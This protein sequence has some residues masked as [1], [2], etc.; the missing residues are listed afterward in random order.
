M[1]RAIAA[2][3]L[4]CAP[5]FAQPATPQ[6][7][8]PKLSFEVASIKPSPPPDPSGFSSGTRG[9]PGRWSCYNTSLTN[10]VLTAF[11][12]KSYQLTAPDWMRRELFDISAKVPAGATKEDIKLMLQNLL[13]E[14]FKLTYHREQKETPA[15]DLVIAK[16]GPKLTEFVEPAPLAEGAPKPPP[17]ADTEGRPLPQPGSSGMT[18]SKNAI[19]WS[20]SKFTMKQMASMLASQLGHPVTD[21]TGLTGF[22]DMQLSWSGT[23]AGMR[24]TVSPPPSGEGG[25]PSAGIPEADSGPT[26][27]T[28]LQQ[29]LGLKLE[30]KKGTIDILVVDKIEKTATEN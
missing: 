4:T 14:R 9:D 3:I 7:A 12:L 19:R 6:P 15:Y 28:A 21:A 30:A 13:E 1:K 27:F 17:R 29:Q 16:N 22:Y 20:G 5:V 24:V 8:T 11:D 26:L 18:M 2:A 25:A 23:G 10:L